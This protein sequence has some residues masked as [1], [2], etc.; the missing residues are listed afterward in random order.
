M[1][2]RFTKKAIDVV[3]F[4]QDE[5]RRLRLDHV[6]TGQILLGLLNGDRG[7][8]SHVLN[9]MGVEFK[10]SRKEVEEIVGRGTGSPSDELPFTAR[11]KKILELSLT[12]IEG[13]SA[14]NVIPDKVTIGGTLRSTNTDTRNDMLEKI[15][16]AAQ[17]ACAINNCS[18]NIG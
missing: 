1:F 16:H 11:A 18:V 2:D 8:G 4:A 5:A 17:G 6:G 15:K 9:S 13:G 12:K 10:N 14:F 7:I 3:I